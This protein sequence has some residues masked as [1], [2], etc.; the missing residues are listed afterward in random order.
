[1]AA[2]VKE[3]REPLPADLRDK[4][5]SAKATYEAMWQ[6][7]LDDWEE[8]PPPVPKF[9]QMVGT[10][11]FIA[12]ARLTH[13]R[14]GGAGSFATGARLREASQVAV[15]ASVHT[16]LMAGEGWCSWLAASASGATP[17]DARM[18]P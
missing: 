16:R 1:M 7:Q 17:N 12:E 8:E 11:Q 3:T 14:A 2:K 9:Q 4:Y 15:K 13:V 5:I 18:R 10:E 6:S